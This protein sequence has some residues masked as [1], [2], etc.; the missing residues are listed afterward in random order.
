[1]VGFKT[2]GNV[3]I[4]TQEF[5]SNRTPRDFLDVAQPSSGDNLHCR[6]ERISQMPGRRGSEMAPHDFPADLLWGVPEE[7]GYVTGEP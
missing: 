1:M 6:F 7:L 2:Q 3:D 4:G 5:E